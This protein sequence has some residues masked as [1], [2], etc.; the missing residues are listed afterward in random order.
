MYRKSDDFCIFGKV[1]RKF[2]KNFN[3]IAWDL[4][5]DLVVV[6]VDNKQKKET[7]WKPEGKRM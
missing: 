2:L 3:L 5:Y 7:E 6:N 4:R 1:D